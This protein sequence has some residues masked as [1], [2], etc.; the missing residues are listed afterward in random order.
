MAAAY[1]PAQWHDFGTSFAAAAGAWLGLAVVAISFNRDPIL[2]L[3]GAARP[4]IDAH[5]RRW[6]VPAG[7]GDDGR[8]HVRAD[9][10]PGSARGDQA[11]TGGIRGR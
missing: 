2:K 4:A 5:Q 1:D 9:Q 10:P 3:W 8:D 6:P 11:L 7:R